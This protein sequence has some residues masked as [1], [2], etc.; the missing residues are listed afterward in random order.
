MIKELIIKFDDLLAL[1]PAILGG[2]ID[3]VNQ[4]YNGQKS[5]SI[6]GFLVHLI[7]ACFF[8][9]VVGSLAAGLHYNTHII[10]AASGVGGFLG[11][12]VADL[13]TWRLIGKDRRRD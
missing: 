2:F 6:A 13:V 11:V 4:L 3:Y 10:A 8:G 7:S 5:W 12:R 1:I 9:W